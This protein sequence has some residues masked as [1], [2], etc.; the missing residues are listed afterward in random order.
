MSKFY[1]YVILLIG[2]FSASLSQ[3]Q[4]V[5]TRV[6]TNNFIEQLS[7]EYQRPSQKRGDTLNL[8]F[9]ED[10]SRQEG[11]PNPTRWMNDYVFV[12]NGY[13]FHKVSQGVATFEGLNE[14]GV[15]YMPGAEN[16]KGPADTLTSAPLNMAFAE[17]DSVYLSFFLQ[18]DGGGE[19]PE[20]TD[21]F[22]VQAKVNDTTWRSI[23]RARGG[24]LSQFSPDSNFVQVLINLSNPKFLYNGF[25]FRFINF[26][27]LSG[28]TD[29]W[30]LDYIK[31]D[32]GRTAND[33]VLNDI[34]IVNQP[35]KVLKD[36]TSMPVSDYSQDELEERIFLGF[37][38]S[39]VV[40]SFFSMTYDL[41]FE[42]N[43]AP[44]SFQQTVEMPSNNE[45]TLL[46]FNL[47]KFDIDQTQETVGVKFKYAI[48][49]RNDDFPQNDTL[50]YT[51]IFANYYSY[52]DG[53]AEYAY[54]LNT[55]GGKLAYKF[56]TRSPQQFE[57]IDMFFSRLLENV[58]NELFTLTI[59]K[60]LNSE[61]IYEKK[62]QRPEYAGQNEFVRYELDSVLTL[63]GEFY[64]GWEQ[65]FSRLL[66]IG[67]D[68]NTNAN[69]SKLFYNVE[70][71]W[72][73][74]SIPGSVMIRPVIAGPDFVSSD[75][76]AFAE[77]NIYPNPTTGL[78]TL[79]GG[80]FK[81]ETLQ[82]VDLSGRSLP[83]EMQGN[84]LDLCNLPYGIYFLRQ[85]GTPSWI[86]KVVKH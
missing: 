58:S 14:K 80:N 64:V 59:W 72:V 45:D 57:A 40:P 26:G 32:T 28:N 13:G 29:H 46:F 44:Y 38:N 7:R 62:V 30:H 78:I 23:W 55:E 49:D 71:S 20:T 21:S 41:K 6:Q 5:I 67:L 35:T 16:S 73:Q 54:G 31:L 47:P 18:P 84:T 61:P 27:N 11:Y 2:I 24:P 36:Y 70:G 82:L 9:F 76:E 79:S 50:E 17:A 12:N 65:R 3:A 85:T 83:F 81:K 63:N 52:D 51:Q 15:P 25:Q 22:V 39:F 34:T 69:E 33:T 1:K 48:Q 74:S 75:F 10:F 43:G 56:T 19:S 53:T 68:R 86:K 42:A 60:D 37:R 77:V 4:E 8:P 66:N